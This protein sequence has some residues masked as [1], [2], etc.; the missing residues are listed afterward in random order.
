MRGTGP[1]AVSLHPAVSSLPRNQYL[2]KRSKQ[3]Q[4]LVLYKETIVADVVVRLQR[5][6]VIGLVGIVVEE[7]LLLKLFRQSQQLIDRRMENVDVAAALIH[8]SEAAVMENHVSPIQPCDQFGIETGIR[9]VAKLEIAEIE[10]VGKGSREVLRE[11][12]FDRE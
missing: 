3:F 1:H 11:A 8:R 6:V 10:H 4:R 7:R 5:V 2:A 12:A 9:A